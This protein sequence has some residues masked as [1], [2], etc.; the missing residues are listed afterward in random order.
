ML[1]SMQANITS[2]TQVMADEAEPFRC[3][4]LYFAG[5]GY[6]RQR[7][8]GWASGINYTKTIEGFCS[9]RIRGMKGIYQHCALK[10]LH[11]YDIEFDLKYKQRTK[12]DDN[13]QEQCQAALRSIAGMGL[14][15][16]TTDREVLTRA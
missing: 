14:I 6:A 11:R 8:H 1:F 2:G 16:N 12:F 5:H 10:H 13:K 3:L 7:Q 9:V 4:C 15:C